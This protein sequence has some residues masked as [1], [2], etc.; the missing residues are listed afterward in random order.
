M[1]HHNNLIHLPSHGPIQGPDTFV[2]VSTHPKL[3]CTGVKPDPLPTN[4]TSPFKTPEIAVQNVPKW[5]KLLWRTTSWDHPTLAK[6]IQHLNN[7][8]LIAAGEGSIRNQWGA[9]H[10]CL[11]SK[12]A[13]IRLCTKTGP[14]DGDPNQM[15]IFR[16]AASYVLS[17]L[18]LFT[19]LEPFITNTTHEYNIYTS[20]QGLLNKIYAPIINC[21]SLVLS[22]HIDIVNQTRALLSSTNLNINIVFFDLFDPATKLAL[23]Q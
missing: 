12:N 14:V 10:G 16:V 1:L 9:Y 18:S 13:H 15:K 11:T 21:P 23:P 17:V 7:G 6:I 5:I 2:D 4:I 22:N 19:T 20:C 8:D 3:K